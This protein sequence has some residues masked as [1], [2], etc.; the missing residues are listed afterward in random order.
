MI[1]LVTYTLGWLLVSRFLAPFGIA[2]EEIGITP[3][4]ILFR[5][6]LQAIPLAGYVVVGWVLIQIR[7]R[8]SASIYRIGQV[9]AVTLGLGFIATRL[10]ATTGHTRSELVLWAASQ[11]VS[12]AAILLIAESWR[13]PSKRFPILPIVAIALLAFSVVLSGRYLWSRADTISHYTELGGTGPI[14]PAV[15]PYLYISAVTVTKLKDDG[16]KKI[17]FPCAT[18]LGTS[19]RTMVILVGDLG[20]THTVWRLPTNQTL[21]RD[22]CVDS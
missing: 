9:A 21:L 17:V 16:T 14:G 3:T 4:W 15:Y 6:P 12:L 13:Q 10:Y 18:F 7:L 5:V 19:N 22:G 8:C 20:D 11:V 2:P 1:A